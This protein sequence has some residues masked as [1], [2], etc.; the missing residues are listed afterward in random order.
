MSEKTKFSENRFLRKS[1]FQE[2]I[3]LEISIFRKPYF[4][5]PVFSENRF[6]D[7]FSKN[8]I[9]VLYKINTYV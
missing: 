7:T 6:S 4:Q 2:T 8:C 1:Y 3:F 9:F 5:R